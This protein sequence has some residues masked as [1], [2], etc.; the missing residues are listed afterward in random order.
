[1]LYTGP[2]PL[3]SLTLQK[4]KQKASAYKMYQ[5]ARSR[6][7][8]EEVKDNKDYP[9]YKRAAEYNRIRESNPKLTHLEVLGLMTTW[10]GEEHV[11]DSIIKVRHVLVISLT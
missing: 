3:L 8:K 6:L 7:W 9:C 11:R 5:N 2:L 4:Q 1:M 10:E